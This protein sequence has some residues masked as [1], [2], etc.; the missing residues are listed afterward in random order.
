MTGVQVLDLDGSLAGQAEWLPAQTAWFPARDW[1]PPLR[2][3][4]RFAEF[5]RF[6]RWLAGTLPEDPGVTLYGSGD[7]HHVTLALLERLPGP[8]HLLVIDKHPDWMRGVPFL[9]CG[10]WLRHALGLPNL[11]RVFHVGGELDFDNAYR[12]LA[13]WRDLRGGRVVVFPARR[14]FTRGTWAAVPTFPLPQS[15]AAVAAAL[16]HALAPYRDELATCPLYVTVDKDV[17]TAEDA[18]V[19]WDSGLLCLAEVAAVLETFVGL[20]GGRLAGADLTGD[21]SP[22][23]LGS[24]LGRAF[25]HLDH[26]GPAHDPAEAA[27]LNG[28]ANAALL[29]ALGVAGLDTAACRD[30]ARG[31][32]PA[33]GGPSAEKSGSV[34]SNCVMAWTCPSQ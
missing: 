29:R 16:A 11:R 31:P 18:A 26:P 23:R 17:L 24:W 14:R 4:C 21:W 7:F 3:A 8:F 1:G 25:H 9:H 34:S 10:T 19:N 20:A 30:P 28:R 12:P 5:A 33:Q 22:V 15:P 2:L 32:W 13:P 27:A 6:R